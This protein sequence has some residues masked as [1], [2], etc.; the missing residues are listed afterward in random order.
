MKDNISMYLPKIIKTISKTLTSHNAQ[1][2]V[3]GGSVRDHFLNLPI[4]DYDIEVYGLD[5]LEELE[6]VLEPYGSVNLVGKSF[7][8]LKFSY[9]GEEYDFSFPRLERKVGEGHRGFVV[10]CDGQMSFAE[11]SLRRDFTINA[12]GYVVESGEFLDPFKGKRDMQDNI[13]RHIDNSSFVEDPLRVYRAVQF[14]ARFR[15]Q[16]ADETLLLC[17]EMV[18]D[19]MLDELPQERVYTEWVKL[20]LK[21]PQPSVGFE[22]MRE[23]GVL[24]YFPE[25]EALIAVPQSPKWHPEG[26]VWVHT[27]MCIDAMVGL[28]SGDDRLDLKLMFAVLCHDLGKATTT[29][30]D[31]EGNI[32]SIGHEYEGVA[33]TE[34]L[35][36]RLTNEHDFIASLLPLVKYHLAP[37]QFYAGKSRDRA[38]RRL[39]TKVTISELVVVAKADFLG[40]TTPESLTGVYRAGEWL[41]EKA[42]NLKVQH[43]PLE[44]LLQGRDLIVLGLQPSAKFKEILSSVY[45]LQI[46]GKVE[47]KEDA[48]E[49]VKKQFMSNREIKELKDE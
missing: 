38:V 15:Y 36:Y 13:L 32:R 20:L 49:Y 14:C 18:D 6:R 37:S 31:D 21:S 25:L 45:S 27:M 4:K 42:K 16:L 44:P 48:L 33:P 1:A 9:D 43:K 41:L 12:M 46:D 22:L 11:A 10:A 47:S 40:R 24:R 30:I 34:S 39:S 5:T 23:L 35:M 7:G 26:D 8:V 28:K 19:G 2:I 3:V 17:K 29:T